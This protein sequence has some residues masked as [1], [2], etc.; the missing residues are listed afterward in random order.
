MEEMSLQYALSQRKRRETS[1]RI[2]NIIN[3]EEFYNHSFKCNVNYKV[4]DDIF[5]RTTVVSSG[6]SD[7]INKTL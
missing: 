2:E 4:E 1:D 5:C 6:N 7:A 3:K